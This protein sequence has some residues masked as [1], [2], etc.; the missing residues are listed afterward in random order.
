MT[1]CKS[2]DKWGLLIVAVNTRIEWTEA[3]WNPI[4]GCTKITDGCTNCYAYSMAKRLYAMGNVRYRNGFKVTVHRDLILQ[5]LKWKKSRMI[6]V[7]SMSDLFHED[8]DFNIIK[9]IFKI[10]QE[11]SQ[12]TFQIITKRSERLL[13]LSPYLPWSNNIWQ[14]VTVENCKYLFRIEHLKKTPAKVKFISFEPLLG[15][16]PEVDLG[17]IDWAIAGGESGPRARPVDINWLRQLR[18]QCIYQRVPFFF[19]Q[20]GGVRKNKDRRLDDEYWNQ[21]PT[22]KMQ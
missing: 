5:P 2:S 15:A 12:H 3:T 22:C 18:D 11:A 7:N 10:M 13:N 9:E 20:W 6:F 1:F 19:K 17:Y 14:G 21:Y 16:I 8:V 4:T